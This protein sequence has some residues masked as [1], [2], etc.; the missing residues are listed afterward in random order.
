MLWVCEFEE[1]HF[2]IQR[3]GQDTK[4]S[5]LCE[6]LRKQGRVW[7]PLASWLSQ[8]SSLTHSIHL[9]VSLG[10]WQEMEILKIPNWIFSETFTRE[11]EVAHLIDLCLHLWMCSLLEEFAHRSA[12]S[13]K[14]QRL[15]FPSWNIVASPLYFPLTKWSSAF[16][17]IHFTWEK[18]GEMVSTLMTIFEIFLKQFRGSD[19]N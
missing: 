5:G 3:Q 8:T 13:E 18:K 6:W 19:Y 10:G 16:T 11:Q 17:C 9:S 1:S 7:E 2:L 14:S 4:V 12:W 15:F